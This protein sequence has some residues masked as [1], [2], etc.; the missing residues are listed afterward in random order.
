[1]AQATIHQH[2]VG[3]ITAKESSVGHSEIHPIDAWIPSKAPGGAVSLG[4]DALADHEVF[5]GIAH[6]K[7]NLGPIKISVGI[8]L[9]FTGTIEYWKG[10]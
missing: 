10:A 7:T 8:D 1:M 9:F 5:H 6:F 2:W 4:T 3:T